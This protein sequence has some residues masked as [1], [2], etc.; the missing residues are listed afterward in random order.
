[1]RRVRTGSGSA[2]GR[3]PYRVLLATLAAV[4]VG[5]APADVVRL[6][7]GRVV[8][9][10]IVARSSAAVT[11]RTPAGLVTVAV[12]QVAAVEETPSVFD[13]YD[14][15]RRAVAD[16][17]QAQ[18]E[19]GRWCGEQGLTGERE[20]HLRRAVEIDRN[21]A[22]AREALGHV[23]IGG[24]WVEGRASGRSPASQPVSRLARPLAPAPPDDGRDSDAAVRAV[25]GSWMRRI[26]AIKT[27]LLDASIERLVKQGRERILE[28][29][30]PLAIVPLVKLLGKGSVTCRE[31]L[32]ESLGRFDD[33][34]ATMNLAVLA[35]V[36][37]NEAVRGAAVAHLVAR[38]DERV[39]AQLRKALDSGEEALILRAAVALG[40]MKRPEAVPDLIGVLTVRRRMKV[41]TPVAKYFGEM[42]QE[43][44]SGDDIHVGGASVSVR[45]RPQIGL[46]D[47]TGLVTVEMEPRLRDVTV[48]RTEVRDALRAITGQDFAFDEEEW[49]RWYQEYHR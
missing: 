30:D 21:H 6:S 23:R 22:A 14:A 29:R 33:D 32:V 41:E 18:Y 13:E 28:I 42:P 38:D 48:F 27:S 37:R 10:D 9:G 15:R 39:V 31:V 17:A 25:Q 11:V 24:L 8:Q 36:D 19:L 26:N 7:D 47:G 45:R 1:M 35:L 40:T 43:F 46:A 3:F 5:A 34:E 16:T 12:E 2:P 44:A 20:K 4:A 49:R